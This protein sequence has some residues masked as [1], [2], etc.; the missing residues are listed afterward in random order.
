MAGQSSSRGVGSV[1]SDGVSGRGVCSGSVRVEGSSGGVST[2]GG[3]S[4]GGKEGL[5][6]GALVT[7]GPAPFAEGA[8]AHEKLNAAITIPRE[9][10]IAFD[11]V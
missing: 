4:G 8:V 6:A 3:S 1:C 5:E 7:K 11:T 9:S 10:P 2:T